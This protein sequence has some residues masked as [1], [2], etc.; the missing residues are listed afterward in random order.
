[1]DCLGS[2]YPA[3][4]SGRVLHPV[5]FRQV[6][7]AKTARPEICGMG[8]RDYMDCRAGSQRRAVP[9]NGRRH[10]VFKAAG[11]FHGAVCI[12]HV[13]VPGEPAFENF[14]GCPVCGF[15]GTVILGVQQPAFFG[16]RLNYAAGPWG[17]Q[18]LAANW[19]AGPGGKFGILCFRRA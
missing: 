18:R 10:P 17:R 3:L 19:L 13:L 5:F 15:A 4:F 8:I 6:C 2:G 7:K 14:S 11:I 12:L 1:M 9:G 16:K